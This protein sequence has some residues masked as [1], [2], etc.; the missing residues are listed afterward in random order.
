MRHFNLGFHRCAFRL[1]NKI[2]G[3]ARLG[4]GGPGRARPGPGPARPGQA[5]PGLGPG[6]GPK[7]IR[8]NSKILEKISPYKDDRKSYSEKLRKV[9]Y[10]ILY[11][12]DPRKT[13]LKHMFPTT[14][15]KINELGKHT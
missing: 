3:P 14:I 11:I 2:P 9:L 13:S 15:Q 5:R 12:R 8:K 7:N 10:Y 1:H 4:P 6:L